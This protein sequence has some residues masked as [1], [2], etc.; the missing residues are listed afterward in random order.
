M[1]DFNRERFTQFIASVEQEIANMKVGEGKFRPG[2]IHFEKDKAHPVLFRLERLIAN[3]T[4]ENLNTFLQIAAQD[5]GTA[6]GK[7]FKEWSHSIFPVDPKVRAKPVVKPFD[8]VIKDGFYD[9]FKVAQVP[10][11]PKQV[12]LLE[13]TSFRLAQGF[14]QKI[15]DTVRE[16]LTALVDK[17]NVKKDAE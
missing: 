2:A 13:K 12:E 17:A 8:L 16:Q 5:F 1:S 14:E 11:T 15:Q 9:M 3:P 7:A 10:L 6:T 4:Q